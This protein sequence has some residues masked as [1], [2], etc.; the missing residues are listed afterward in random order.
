MKNP[1]L[2]AFVRTSMYAYPTAMHQASIVMI[3]NTEVMGG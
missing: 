1:V 3:S 2:L